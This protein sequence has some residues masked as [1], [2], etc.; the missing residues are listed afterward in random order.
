MLKR[1]I[2]EINQ[3][4]EIEITSRVERR[5]QEHELL[6]TSGRKDYDNQVIGLKQEIERLRVSEANMSN[7]I[8]E[9]NRKILELTR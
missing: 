4:I 3:K 8:N 1:Q 9:S 7:H 5:L 2:Q 6:K